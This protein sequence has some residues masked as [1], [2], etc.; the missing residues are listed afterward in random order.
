MSCAAE[1][2][3]CVSPNSLGMLIRDV[4]DGKVKPRINRVNDVSKVTGYFNLRTRQLNGLHKSNIIINQL[5]S[6]T[7]EDITTLCVDRPGWIID[8]SLLNNQSIRL[9]RPRNPDPC[10]AVAIDGYRL[11]QEVEIN[12][13]PRP[14]ITISTCGKQVS[15]SDI[16]GKDTISIL[17]IDRVI[18]LLDYTT[19]CIGKTI[20]DE[21]QFLKQ[22][23]TDSKVV[24]VTF[25]SE[26]QR[27]HLMSTSCLLLQFRGNACKSCSYVA[28]LFRNKSFKRKATADPFPHNKCNLRFFSNKGLEKKISNQRKQLNSYTKKESRMKE[29]EMIELVQRKKT[30]AILWKLRNQ[31]T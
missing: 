1:E 8:S 29:T 28:K 31:A 27:N 11:T 5:T 20:E 10:K 4:W 18:C 6:Q 3:Q 17:T 21:D 30:V 26:E 2:P 15:V 16:I 9:I 24:T 14:E 13:V 19:P 12:M 23:V 25:D 22:G 7:V